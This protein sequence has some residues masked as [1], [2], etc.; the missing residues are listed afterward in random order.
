MEPPVQCSR[1]IYLCSGSKK[2]RMVT[3]VQKNRFWQMLVRAMGKHNVSVAIIISDDVSK[4]KAKA[5]HVGNMGKLPITIDEPSFLADL[6]HWKWV[7]AGDIYNLSAS[8]QKKSNVSKGISGQ[9]TYW[10]GACVVK[11]KKVYT[12]KIFS[13]LS[14]K[15]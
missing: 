13:G 8:P 15:L 7:F 12:S 1:E 6:S 4:C 10:Y 9:L 5:K 3:D 14:L 2:L 11:S